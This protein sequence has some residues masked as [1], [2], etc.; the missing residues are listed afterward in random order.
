MST[1][2]N[3]AAPLIAAGRNQLPAIVFDVERAMALSMTLPLF[4]AA[5]G[6]GRLRVRPAT[7]K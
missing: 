1:T 7:I 5:F 6:R 2:C 3:D 4:F